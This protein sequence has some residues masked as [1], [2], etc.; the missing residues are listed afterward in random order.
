MY[1][2][3]NY[4][5]INLIEGSYMPSIVKSKNSAAFDFWVRALFQRAMS[6]IIFN[7]L[8]EEWEGATRDFFYYCLF[9]RGYVAGFRSEQYGIAFQPCTLTGYDFYYQPTEALISNPVYNARLRIGDECELIKLT[10]DY[11]GVW[12]IICYYAEKLATLDN[13][14]NMSIINSKFA[15]LIGAKNKA[16]AETLKK[17][18]D[19]INAGEPMAV[20]DEKLLDNASDKSEPW[21]FLERK[22]LKE[23]YLTSMQL[24]DF[25]TLMNNFDT[26]IG[27]PTLA[28]QKKER[29]IVSEAE[30]R[31]IDAT[32]RSVIWYDTLNSSLDRVNKLLGTNISV[33]LRYKE[34]NDNGEDNNDRL[35]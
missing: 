5:E 25:Q 26:E 10:P 16:A 24:A 14:I 33:T 31:M 6:T 7:N 22:N 19:K 27:I 15:W 35:L 8:P 28:Y 29:M 11:I 21:Q 17:I 12:D 34:E 9:K 2:P 20:F 18:F 23:S 30:S 32:S 4:D 3:Y 13:A 1:S